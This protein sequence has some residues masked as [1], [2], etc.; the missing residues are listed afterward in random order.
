MKNLFKRTLLFYYL[1]FLSYGLSAQPNEAMIFELS[2]DNRHAIAQEVRDSLLLHSFGAAAIPSVMELYHFF[3][4]PFNNRLYRYL[5]DTVPLPGLRLFEVSGDLALRFDNL[6]NTF[7]NMVL[8]GAMDYL[9]P[10]GLSFV[11]THGPEVYNGLNFSAGTVRYRIYMIATLSTKCASQ[12]Y[13]NLEIVIVD[14]NIL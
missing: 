7:G 6:A 2:I 12:C 5:P 4:I 11:S 14:K 3:S 1:L 8:V 10:E 9:N 13:G